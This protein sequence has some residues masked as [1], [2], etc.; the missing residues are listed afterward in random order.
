MRAKSMLDGYRYSWETQSL[1]HIMQATEVI[2]N[3][4]VATLKNSKI[5]VK[6]T[7][8]LYFM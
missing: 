2:Q 4:L 7:S 1:R 8:R 6:L 5:K 3:F